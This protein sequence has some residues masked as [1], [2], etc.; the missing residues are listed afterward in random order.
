MAAAKIKT[1]WMLIGYLAVIR[2]SLSVSGVR[3]HQAL[4]MPRGLCLKVV[5]IIYLNDE[6][7]IIL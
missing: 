2:K 4:T 7:H 1:K 5:I 3:A 6:K